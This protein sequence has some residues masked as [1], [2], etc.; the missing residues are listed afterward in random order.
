M[1]RAEAPRPPD[2]TT[3]RTAVAST[4]LGGPRR[5]AVEDREPTQICPL[6]SKILPPV[7]QPHVQTNRPEAAAPFGL[8]C[9]EHGCPPS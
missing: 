4:I 7:L 2:P 9:V 5:L 3:A 6:P 8:R 1:H